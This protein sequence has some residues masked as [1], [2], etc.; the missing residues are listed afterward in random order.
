MSVVNIGSRLA[1]PAHWRNL[2][3]T[4]HFVQFYDIEEALLESAGGFIGAALSA[5]SAGI[6][7][8]TAAH[9]GA[10]AWG[11]RAQG[12]DFAAACDRG[13]YVAL[14]AAETLAQVTVEGEPNRVRFL[15]LLGPIFA[16]ASNRFGRVYAFGEMVAL[17]WQNGDRDAAH[18]LEEL[19]NELRTHHSFSLFCAYPMSGFD[20]V[21]H[22]QAFVGLCTQHSTVIPAESYSGQ[23][24]PDERLLTICRLQQKA[25]ALEREV[26]RREQLEGDLAQRLAE[27]AEAAQRKDEF[28]AM[29][30]H[31]LR[32][33]LAPIRNV[34]EALCRIDAEDSAHRPMYE[35]LGRQVR[36]LTRLLDDLLDV[37]RITQGK[38]QLQSE[39]LELMAVIS[40]A[41]ETCR[42]LIDERRLHLG[43]SLP[44]EPVRVRGDRARLVQVFANLLNNAAKY[45]PEN[46]YIA[47]KAERLGDRVKVRVQ[48][49]GMGIAADVLPKIFDLFAQANRTLDRAEGG[50]GIG[51]TIVRTIVQLHAGHVEA[52]SDGAGRGSEFVVDLPVLEATPLGDDASSSPP[53]AAGA[54]ASR[55]RIVVVDDNRDSADSMA[56]FL[57]LGGHEVATVF[58]G[59][60]ALELVRTFEPDVVLLDLGLPGMNGYEVAERVRAF[61]PDVRIIAVTGY[62]QSGDRRRTRDAGFDH[63]LVK[64][65]DPA[66]LEKLF[67]R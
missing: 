39:S 49:D 7:I 23:R 59:A 57:R 16:T 56:V 3:D 64:P 24:T 4:G 58:D 10:L 46:G 43:V 52:S 60:S 40:S 14:D 55:Q 1:P 17:L 6:V 8:A 5:G 29:L 65:V 27:L 51:L 44:E 32:N 48:D 45:T 18:R 9:H 25:T 67:A 2:S 31:E 50:L 36:Q 11:L 26:A 54:A 34:V 13:Q 61:D 21:S 66:T 22:A 63:H 35:M 28:L 33:P 19:W 47:I 12:I 42:P 20:S 37:A 62:G 38:I 30:G 41:I 15:N 53:R